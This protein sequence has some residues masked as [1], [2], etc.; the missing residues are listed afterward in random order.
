[1]TNTE[2]RPLF[3]IIIPTKDRAEYLHHTLRTCSIQDYEN[4]EVIVSDDGSSDNTKEVALEASRKDTRI[5]YITPW[6]C[7]TISSS[8]L[9]M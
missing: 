6:E 9:I 2:S 7:E 8:L 1:M 3:T 4:L 5:R